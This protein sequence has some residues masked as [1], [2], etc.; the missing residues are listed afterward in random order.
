MFFSLVRQD[1]LHP[2]DLSV[3]QPHFDPARMKRG[4][5]KDVLYDPDGAFAGSL[6]L[7]QN[8]FD[9]FS[10]PNFASMLTIHFTF[11]SAPGFK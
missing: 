10:G 3:N 7:F 5:S 6:V 2:P 11:S 9:S 8:N 4:R 1:L